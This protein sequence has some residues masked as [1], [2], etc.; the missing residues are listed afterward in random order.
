MTKKKK[1]E[2]KSLVRREIYVDTYLHMEPR[3][4]L[5]RYADHDYTDS[6]HF[7][8]SVDAPI[9]FGFVMPPRILFSI[10]KRGNSNENWL[11][12]RSGEETLA[13]LFCALF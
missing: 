8:S 5:I 9:L 7:H 2:Q 12:A 10:H 4:A 6:E 1:P 11:I 3:L 13:P